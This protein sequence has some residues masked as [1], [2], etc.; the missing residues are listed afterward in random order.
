MKYICLGCK[1]EY[2]SSSG[3]PSGIK[4]NDGHVCKPVQVKETK[5]K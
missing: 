1:T 4:W 2:H 5:K 3:T